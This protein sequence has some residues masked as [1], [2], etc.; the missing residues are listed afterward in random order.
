M[1]EQDILSLAVLQCL[2]LVIRA[3]KHHLA[4]HLQILLSPL[5]LQYLLYPTYTST[6]LLLLTK[7]SQHVELSL[8]LPPLLHLHAFTHP[9]PLVRA[10]AFRIVCIGLTV[11]DK[12]A[13]TSVTDRVIQ[14]SLLTIAL[15]GVEDEEEEVK[16]AGIELLWLVYDPFFSMQKKIEAREGEIKN[17]RKSFFSTFVREQGGE[18]LKADA[19]SCLLVK[20]LE[21]NK[22]EGQGE[23]RQQEQ[24]VLQKQ[25]Q[26]QQEQQQVEKD[27]IQERG[28]EKPQQVT[29]QEAPHSPQSAAS[30]VNR[31][32][33]SNFRWQASDWSLIP[34]PT[35]AT[36]PRSSEIKA[37]PPSSSCVSS[38]S[39]SPP[40]FL[41]PPFSPPSPPRSCR[42][43]TP[44]I[45]QRSPIQEKGLVRWQDNDDLVDEG[46]RKENASITHAAPFSCSQPQRRQRQ[47]Q[48]QR[49]SSGHRPISS[50]PRH[51]LHGKGLVEWCD[52]EEEE[53]KGCKEGYTAAT[54]NDDY[55]STHAPSSQP[56][57]S[58]FRSRLSRLSH[59]SSSSMPF[60]SPLM[61]SPSPPSALLIEYLSPADIHP[62]PQP[63]IALPLLL[64]SLHTADWPESFHALTTVRRFAH[65]HLALLLTLPSDRLQL[66]L[67]Q[68]LRHV[69]NLRSAVAKNA[70]LALADLWA[71]LASSPSSLSS[72][73]LSLSSRLSFPSKSNGTE[74]TV[75]RVMEGELPAV[76]PVLLKRFCDTNDFLVEAAE[77]ALN[78]IILHTPDTTRVLHAFLSLASHKS[79]TGR[80]KVASQVL[81]CLLVLTS[82]AAGS[83]SSAV[84]AACGGVSPRKRKTKI[85]IPAMMT[86]TGKRNNNAST[87]GLLGKDLQEW[88]QLATQQ[89]LKDANC[90]TRAQGRKIAEVLPL[91]VQ[92]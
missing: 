89:W 1:E 52:E 44:S 79:P 30:L 27:Q 37:F 15:D 42:Q 92:R 16:E 78:T 56:P 24:Q 87:S 35:F 46:H 69:N 47:R 4:N 50:P 75:Q 76:I 49:P 73:P 66:L 32:K 85:S 57:T 23:E 55:S 5:L 43:H 71:G 68:V 62:L 84:T 36:K 77:S 33:T 70:L 83:L 7:L 45:P 64:E 2:H 91:L 3:G 13:F 11:K 28:K 74:I 34:R 88:L 82:A 63:S 60:R 17:E 19:R 18:T 12:V 20:V 22:E 86:I 10:A 9:S 58:P 54:A 40:S 61:P 21:E 65:Q 6:I 72:S 41:F 14:E 81:R 29:K 26:Q 25:L 31:A 53:E 67:R 90:E 38:A 80:S 48:R 8:L 39:T 59:T 51:L